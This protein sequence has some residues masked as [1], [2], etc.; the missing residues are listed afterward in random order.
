MH[1]GRGD[2]QKGAKYSEQEP[3]PDKIISHATCLKC[4]A[5]KGPLGWEPTPEFF[6][7][8]LCDIFDEVKRVLAAHGGC[9]VNLGDTYAGKSLCQIPYR[10]AIEMSNRGWFH[11]NTI[12][13][14]GTTHDYSNLSA[15]YH[16][17]SL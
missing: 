4:G 16:T 11:R 10:F 2:A 1:N 6:I 12:V 7:K 5:W 13:C 8:H 14:D 15:K 17:G 9:W 3:I